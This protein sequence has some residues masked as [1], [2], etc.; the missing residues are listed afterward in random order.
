MGF[1]FRKSTGF[2]P[3]RLNFSKSGIGVSTGVKGAR[4]VFS[5]KGTYVHLGRNGFYYRKH[6]SS[7]N[8]QNYQDHVNNEVPTIQRINDNQEIIE[9]INF[10]NLT[11]IDS[12]EFINEL[13]SKNSKV[14]YFN[15]VLYFGVIS[16]IAFAFYFFLPY[17]FEKEE[18]K[19]A[20]VK[21][22]VVNI[23]SE[24]N[25]ES[26]KVTQVFYR[27]EL[28]IVE[29]S[30]HGDWVQISTIDGSGYIYL[31][32]VDIESRIHTRRVISRFTENKV[33]TYILSILLIGIWIY[34][35]IKMLHLDKK[36]KTIE[37]YY[38]L[39]EEMN[40][41]Y[42][43]FLNSFNSF[44]EVKKVWQIRT[45]SSGHDSKYHGGASTLIR[46]DIVSKRAQHRLPMKYL[47]TNA[48]IPFIGLKNLE[49]FFLPE[50]LLIK[51]GEKFASIM[52]KNLRF[53]SKNTR[54]IEDDSVSSDSKI[55]DFTWK[56]VNRDGGPD[57]RF[58]NNKKIPVCLY[59]EYTLESDKGLYE[60][61]HTSKVNGFEEFR[62][63]LNSIS[64]MQNSQVTNENLDTNRLTG[65]VLDLVDFLM[66]RNQLNASDLQLE[67]NCNQS[68]ANRFIELFSK[69]Y[70]IE[71]LNEEYYQ[72]NHDRLINFRKELDV[73]FRKI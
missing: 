20:V 52:Y 3:I 46:R 7:K 30:I 67:L 71:K 2:G 49:L 53:S 31:P 44:I 8:K 16:L 66:K 6:F 63:V 33:L 45:S 42:G 23:R 24:P 17:D 37:L 13:E 40:D 18:T 72:I 22:Q 70:V 65:K 32:L 41:L 36:R 12:Q 69:S 54:F 47:K 27:D 55:I 11:D 64:H 14:S 58:S 51:Q 57:R 60:I 25:V 68:E 21:S 50:R 43:R 59:T 4:L 29:D 19:V 73:Y 56:Y 5:P 39:D 9:T 26:G 48:R 1:F 10:D 34:S 62:E 61:L 35:M 15:I 28:Q 38:D